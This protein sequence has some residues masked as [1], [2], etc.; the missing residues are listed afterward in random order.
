MKKCFFAVAL[1]MASASVIAD[2]NSCIEISNFQRGTTC[3]NPASASMRVTNVCSQS[4]DMQYC[5]KRA[6]GTWD[7]GMAFNTAPGGSTTYY[8]CNGDMQGS[9]DY[10]ARPAGSNERFP[11][12]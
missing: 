2:M 5:L 9:Y 1:I 7:C 10:S 6:N 11:V 8:T 4:I 12:H 3:N